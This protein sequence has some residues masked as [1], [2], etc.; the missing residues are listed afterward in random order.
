MVNEYLGVGWRF[1]VKVDGLSG[2]LAMSRGERD[3]EESIRIILFT[4]KGERVMRPDFGCGI[5]DYVFA[6]LNTATIGLMESSVREA[7]TRWEPRI[8]VQSVTILQDPAL[9]DLG[10]L[11]IDIHYSVR[12]TNQPFNLVFPFY[13]REG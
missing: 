4:A 7:L 12:S 10:K 5:H 11:V 1:P 2:K 3:I 9:I 13:V 8:Q 6:S